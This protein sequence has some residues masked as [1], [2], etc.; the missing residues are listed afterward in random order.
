MEPLLI[1]AGDLCLPQ[2]YIF[3]FSA[4]QLHN[5]H[6]LLHIHT[7]TFYGH[8]TILLSV[9]LRENGYAT[10]QAVEKAPKFTYRQ[11]YICVYAYM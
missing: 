3:Q 11:I 10:Y 5:T 1:A 6:I 4:I 8:P 7:H 2:E 9:K